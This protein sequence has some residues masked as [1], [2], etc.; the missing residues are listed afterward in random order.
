[1]EKVMKSTEKKPAAIS[2]KDREQ[3]GYQEG[4]VSVIVNTLLFGLK[5]WAGIASGSIA[6]IADDWHTLSDTFTSVVV[7]IGVKLSSR[8]ADKE[9]P[10]GHGRWEQVASFFIGFL[11]A[12]VAYDFLVQS[13][14]KINAHESAHFGTFAIVATV[15]SIV[16]QRSP[17]PICF[18]NCTEN[19]EFIHQGRRLASPFR[20]TFVGGCPCRD[21]SEK[22]FLVDRQCSWHYY[23]ADVVLRGL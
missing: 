9:H 19:T 7:I 18:P 22:L 8:K 1:M 16:V 2:E 15:T 6:I 21:F 13:I 23:F 12:I 14:R 20:C 10:F 11:L 5:Y 17:C 4:I 3:L